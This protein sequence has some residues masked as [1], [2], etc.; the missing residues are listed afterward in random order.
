[1]ASHSGESLEIS[2]NPVP[3]L[4]SNSDRVDEESSSVFWVPKFFVT[5]PSCISLHKIA[6]PAK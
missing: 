3:K 6:Y 4:A 5:L 2:Q 1:M